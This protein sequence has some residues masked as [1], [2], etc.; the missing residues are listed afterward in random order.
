LPEGRERKCKQSLDDIEE[1]RGYEKF[2][3]EEIDHTVWRTHFGRGYGPV[4]RQTNE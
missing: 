2:K 4:G 1:T 3:E